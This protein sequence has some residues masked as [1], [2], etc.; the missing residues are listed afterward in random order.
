VFEQAPQVGWCLDVPSQVAIPPTRLE[1]LL[2]IFS[3]KQ[4][5]TVVRENHSAEII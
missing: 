5:F 3:C 2:N 4:Q 1:K